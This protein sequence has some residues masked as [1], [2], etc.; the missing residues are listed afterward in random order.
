MHLLIDMA[1]NQTD[2]LTHQQPLLEVWS[3]HLVSSARQTPTE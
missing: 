2:L 1:C 3:K